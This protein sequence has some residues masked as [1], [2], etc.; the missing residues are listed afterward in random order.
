MTISRRSFLFGASAGTLA[1]LTRDGTF[2][3]ENGAITRPVTNFRINESPVQMLARCDAMTAPAIAER[4]RVPA[5]SSHE[6]H[7]ASMSEAV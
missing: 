2:P 5:L 6:F 3:I 1:A 4:A 7:L